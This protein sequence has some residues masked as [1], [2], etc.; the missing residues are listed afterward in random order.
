[1][2]ESIHTRTLAEYDAELTS[3]SAAP[4]FKTW[5]NFA[6]QENTREHAYLF[7]VANMESSAMSPRDS[8]QRD[9]F[10]PRV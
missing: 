7:V 1:M 4:N 9:L 5:G 10:F 8:P 6:Y 2:Y 3:M